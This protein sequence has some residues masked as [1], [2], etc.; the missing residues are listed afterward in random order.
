MD[1]KQIRLSNLR[2]L[3]SESGTIA[4]LAR[5]SETAPAYLSQILNSLPTSTGKP[6]SV[7]D[8]LARK[9]EQALNKSYGW[10]DKDH[11]SPDTAHLQVVQHVPLLDMEQVLKHLSRPHRYQ[12]EMIPVP[13]ETSHLAFAI[14]MWDESM[15]P[16]FQVGDIIVIDP[17]VAPVANDFVFCVPGDNHDTPLLRL[18]QDTDGRQL[19]AINPGF[20]SHRLN[21]TDKI[22]G[23]LVYHG[24]IF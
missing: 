19:V 21:S 20:T 6:R 18:M 7:G 14:R 5:L 15:S 11:E 10:M 4:N 24:E 8:K 16:K 22:V 13:I 1:I 23:K 9:L 17:E 3:I 2:T 12:G